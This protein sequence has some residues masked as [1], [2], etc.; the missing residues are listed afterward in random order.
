MKHSPL[1]SR[2]VF[3]LKQYSLSVGY[4]YTNSFLKQVILIVFFFCF[5]INLFFSLKNN[6]ATNNQVVCS[7]VLYLILILRKHQPPTILS[8]FL[9]VPSI[10]KELT[11][12]PAILLPARLPAT[13]PIYSYSLSPP[14]CSMP[15]LLL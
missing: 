1:I 3:N 8:F 10:F 2:A 11:H 4:L 12:S 6:F 15:E 5:L 9:T 13:R 14:Q 7:F